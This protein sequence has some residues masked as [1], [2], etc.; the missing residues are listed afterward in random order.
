MTPWFTVQVE[1]M[2]Q[3]GTEKFNVGMYRIPVK[4][5]FVKVG[6]GGVF[7]EFGVSRVVLGTKSDPFHA[8]VRCYT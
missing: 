4:G 7:G 2:S 3:K 1:I 5:D 6:D 8:Y